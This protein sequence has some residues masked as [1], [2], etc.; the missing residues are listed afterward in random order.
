MYNKGV[1]STPT[2]ELEEE[3]GQKKPKSRMKLGKR[4]HGFRSQEL[5]AMR[6]EN[7]KKLHLDEKKESKGREWKHWIREKPETPRK[8]FG[9]GCTMSVCKERQL[10][11]YQF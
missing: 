9:P 7:L 2:Q 3:T 5:G 4:T 8:C 1:V 10:L 6:R 11:E